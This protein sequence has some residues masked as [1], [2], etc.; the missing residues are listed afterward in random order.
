MFGL[1]DEIEL[2]VNSNHQTTKVEDNHWIDE[3]RVV[4]DRGCDLGSIRSIGQCRPLID[5]LRLRVWKVGK[6]I[7]F[8]LGQTSWIFLRFVSVSMKSIMN[9]NISTARLSIYLNRMSYATISHV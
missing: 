2:N 8:E 1:E 6:S 4:L 9:T 5:D 3:L 7:G